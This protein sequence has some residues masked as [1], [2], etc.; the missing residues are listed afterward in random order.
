MKCVLAFIA[1]GLCVTVVISNSLEYEKDP[2]Y[3]DKGEP[4]WLKCN[5]CKFNIGKTLPGLHIME[6]KRYSK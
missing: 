4:A 2:C 6:W 3:C 5:K 1:L